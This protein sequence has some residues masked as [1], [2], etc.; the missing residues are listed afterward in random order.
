[1]P[2]NVR[3]PALPVRIGTTGKALRSD[4]AAEEIARAVALGAMAKAVHEIGAA[5]PG[6]RPSLIRNQEAAVEEQQFPDADIP[7]DVERKRQIVVAHLACTRG[8]RLQVGEEIAD[9]LCC[10]V[11][12][13]GVWKGRKIMR[14]LRR[15]SPHDRSDEIGLRPSPD[16]VTRILRNVRGI[17]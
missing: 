17:E 8:Q 12:I 4:D 7:P 15:Y 10:R 13:G 2:G 14:P 6:W 5:I 1:L 3:H 9:V 11:R 16:S